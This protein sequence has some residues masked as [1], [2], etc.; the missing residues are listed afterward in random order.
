VDLLGPYAD[1]RMITG[2]HTSGPKCPGCGRRLVDWRER[3]SPWLA[4]GDADWRCPA[5]GHT[6]PVADWRWRHQAAFG[7]LLVAV[8][9]IFP[10]EGVPA[11]A[12]LGALAEATAK[13]WHYAWAATV[14]R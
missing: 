3:A 11:E 7:R 9:E 5:C 12:L 6:A 8:R 2:P 13:P 1:L 14:S 4:H 10:S